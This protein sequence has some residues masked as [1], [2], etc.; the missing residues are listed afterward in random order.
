MA[1]DKEGR[2]HLG[3]TAKLLIWCVTLIVIFYANTAYLFVKLK[4]IVSVSN[5]I[6]VVNNDVDETAGLLVQQLLSVEE[7]LKRYLIL[8]KEAQLESF[9]I[10]LV[11]YG[12]VLKAMRD[13]L[14]D[15]KIPWQGLM[16]AYDAQFTGDWETAGP[17]LSEKDLDNWLEVLVKVRERN[18]REMRQRL[19]GLF[20]KGE[21][22]MYV[23]LLGLTTAIAV[24]LLGSLFLAYRVRRPLRELKRGIRDFGREGQS[25]PIRVLSHDELGDL[26]KTFNQLMER[27]TREEEMR[28]DFISMLSHEIRTPLTSI[29]ETV[30]LMEDGT[31]GPVN[32]RQ[33]RFLGIASKELLRLSKLLERLMMVSSLQSRDIVLTPAPSDPVELVRGAVERMAAIANRKGLNIEVEV[34]WP[35]GA[36]SLDTENIRQVLLNLIGNALKFSPAGSTV[37]VGARSIR[38]GVA[39]SGVVFWVADRGP[40]I[41]EEEQPFVFQK[42]YRGSLA[43]KVDGAGLG[44]N[45]SKR[46]VEAHGGEMR[47]LSRLGEGSIFSFHLPSTSEVG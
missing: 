3:I 36:V 26:T 44:L 11:K 38:P 17:K 35:G 8:K 42:Y 20:D 21:S 12:Q 22:I 25:A 7:A 5:H 45:I 15:V 6:V 1:N 28:T 24:A 19:L 33:A 18:K 40:G 27:L 32:E 30:S 13:R 34:A 2:F 43:E 9:Y 37:R 41:P 10:Q 31:L 14:P 23:G 4:E 16:D 39:G 46:I 29:K 47:L